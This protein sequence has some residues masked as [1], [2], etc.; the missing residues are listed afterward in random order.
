MPNDEN[1]GEEN[2]D[3]DVLLA[4]L[5]TE[6]EAEDEDEDEET[7]DVSSM[8]DTEV[9]EDKKVPAGKSFKKVDERSASDQV[10]SMLGICGAGTFV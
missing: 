8:L 2:L 4:K 9:V 10:P 7:R 1:L 3:E 6:A 5:V